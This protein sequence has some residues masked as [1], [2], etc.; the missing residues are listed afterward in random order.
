MNWK[1][2]STVVVIALAAGVLW[3]QNE[4]APASS[5]SDQPSLADAARVKAKL[6]SRTVI[7]NDDIPPSA[8]ANAPAPAPAASTTSSAAA[9]GSAATPAASAAGKP[10]D[11]KPDAKDKEKQTQLQKLQEERDSLDKV[12]AQLQ[13][14][15]DETNEENRKTTFREVIKHAQEQ[16]AKVQAEI[17]KLKAGGGNQQAQAPAAPPK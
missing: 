13:K 6:K 5:Q 11:A 17:D 15:I 14:Q 16:Q 3:A 8:Q 9:G 2:W 12:I 1:R 4:Q 10:G 7:T